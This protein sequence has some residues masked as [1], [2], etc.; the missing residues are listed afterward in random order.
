LSF[1]VVPQSGDPNDA[2]SLLAAAS[3][4]GRGATDR[5]RT[6]GP[7][8]FVIARAPDGSPVVLIRG[9]AAG[10]GVPLSFRDPDS[11]MIIE[12]ANMGQVGPA[13]GPLGGTGA[14]AGASAGRGSSAG[15]PSSADLEAGSESASSGGGTEMLEMSALSLPGAGAAVLPTDEWS[16]DDEAAHLV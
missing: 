6:T 14:G 13:V 4:V 11:P 8:T 5:T 16:D 15:M 9:G 2:L 10:A 3:A 7:P 12:W 1:H